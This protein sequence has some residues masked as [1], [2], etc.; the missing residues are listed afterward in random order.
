MLGLGDTFLIKTPP[1]NRDH[2]FILV[3]FNENKA[4]LV[5]VTSNQSDVTCKLYRGNHRFLTH[6]SYINY[7]DAMMAEISAIENALRL[8]VISSHD[9]VSSVLLSR[10]IQGAKNSPNFNPEYLTYL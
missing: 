3:A 1:S 9:A 2:L 7:K 5:N 8:G 10:I 4:L 6:T